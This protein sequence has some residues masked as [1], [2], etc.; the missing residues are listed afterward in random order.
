LGAVGRVYDP[1][2]GQTKGY[3]ID[4]CSFSFVSMNHLRGKE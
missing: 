3:K 1:R 4:I 2:S